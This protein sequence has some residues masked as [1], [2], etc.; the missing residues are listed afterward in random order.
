[1]IPLNLAALRPQP[2]TITVSGQVLSVRPLTAGQRLELRNRAEAARAAGQIVGDHVLV[3]WS[4]VDDNGQCL[5][6]EDEAA[7]LDGAAV[8]TIAEEVLKLSQLDGQKGPDA[9]E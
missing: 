7:L 8:A 5:L 9:G 2:T 3:A 4:V 6:S 1:M